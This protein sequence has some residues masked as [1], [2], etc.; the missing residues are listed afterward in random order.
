[1]AISDLA[2]GQEDPK[3]I[4]AAAVRANGYACEQPK[5]VVPDPQDTSPDE[6][7]WILQCEANAYWVKFKGDA[8]VEVELKKD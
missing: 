7:A 1:L 2:I 3:D 4:V 5:S 8:S 6:K